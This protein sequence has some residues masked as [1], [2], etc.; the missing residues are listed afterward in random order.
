ML[1]VFIKCKVTKNERNAKRKRKFFL[2]IPEYINTFA[3]YD[4]DKIHKKAK[5]MI[6]FLSDFS[7][8]Q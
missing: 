4:Y 2:F 6:I 3:K 8:F 1:C 7:A 5:E